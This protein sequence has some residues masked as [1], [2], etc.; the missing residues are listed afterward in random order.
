MSIL[1]EARQRLY[2]VILQRRDDLAGFNDQWENE[3]DDVAPFAVEE[4]ELQQT[5]LPR[6]SLPEL[7]QS[8]RVWLIG[9]GADQEGASRKR[10]HLVDQPIQVCLQA[11]VDVNNHE[12][13][14][15]FILL[16]EQLQECARLATTAG[17]T[18]LRNVAL[19]DRSNTPYDFVRLREAHTFESV[20]T[21]YYRRGTT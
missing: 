10:L 8:P 15:Q 11:K 18:W 5:Y 7:E 14:E 13:I 17:L 12:Q 20:F 21:A 4:F 6:V 1:I 19:K 3:E 2:D 9:L 16:H